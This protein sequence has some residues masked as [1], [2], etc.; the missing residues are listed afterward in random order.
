MSMNNTTMMMMGKRLVL[1]DFAAA[2]RYMFPMAGLPSSWGA[3]WPTHRARRR[4]RTGA[5]G[6]C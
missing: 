3:R 2:A 5:F 6:C 4:V 1:D